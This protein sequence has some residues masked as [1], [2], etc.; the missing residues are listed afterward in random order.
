MSMGV[1]F[2]TH[3]MENGGYRRSR[4]GDV[5]GRGR[6]NRQRRQIFHAPTHHILKRYWRQI[7]EA[8]R[9]RGHSLPR[10]FPLIFR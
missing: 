9:V 8:R 4:A 6:G 1:I 3:D 7:L 2:I 5:S 10:R